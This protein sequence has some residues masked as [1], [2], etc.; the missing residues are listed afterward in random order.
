MRKIG[1]VPIYALAFLAC[2]SACASIPV[3]DVVRTESGTVS[4]TYSGSGHPVVVLQSGLG[5]GRRAWSSVYAT[6]AQSH[7]VFA[8]DRPGYGESEGVP[9]TRDPCGIA[10]ELHSLLKAAQV[11]PP[12]I[13]VGHSIGGLYQYAFAKL[14]PVEVAGLVLL[15]PTHPNHWQ[16]L[17]QDVPT[18]AAVVRGLRATVF[19]RAMRRE[20][21]DQ[22][23]CNERLEGLP[24]L[25]MP[26]RVLTRSR[27]PVTESAAFESM[28]RSLEPDWLRLSGARRIDRV[29]DSG[30]YIQ[31][32]Q[33]AAVLAAIEAVIAER[34]SRRSR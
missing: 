1:S 12:Y 3:T 13:L 17:Q 7:A 5:D 34:G 27:F 2:L 22:A 10:A 28:V 21:D 6:L 31:G 24:K 19:S 25:E 20:F 29:D 30:H 26:A 8:Y 32:D 16:R 15:D 14:Y 33:P 11:A 9:Q 4:Y 23:K 18:M